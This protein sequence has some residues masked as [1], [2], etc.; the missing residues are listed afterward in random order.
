M[1][2][3]SFEEWLQHNENDGYKAATKELDIVIANLLDDYFTHM[4]HHRASDCWKSVTCLL[5]YLLRL[6]V[7][8]LVEMTTESL[9]LSDIH[10]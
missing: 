8:R 2:L 10:M 7:T 9:L 4:Y 1:R 6:L 5:A 3:R